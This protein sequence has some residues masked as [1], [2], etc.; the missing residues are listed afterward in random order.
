[1][2]CGSA[3]STPRLWAGGPSMMMLIQRICM[4]LSGFGVSIRVDSVI[5]ESAAMLVLIWNR[6]KFLKK[7][8]GGEKLIGHG[9]HLQDPHIMGD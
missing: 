9:Q 7:E 4:G 3:G 1:M 6:T 5:R 2:I 8:K